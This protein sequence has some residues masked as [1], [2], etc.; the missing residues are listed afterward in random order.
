MTAEIWQCTDS[1][2][3]MRFPAADHE[4]TRRICP[5]CG[6]PTVR[7]RVLAVEPGQK[8]PQNTAVPHIELLLDN[9]RSLHNV[10]S[11]FRT[12]DGAG[13][14]KI[15]L[16]GITATPKHPKLAKTALGAEQRIPWAYHRNGV[17]AVQALREEGLT[18]WGLEEMTTAIS[19][20][21]LPPQ[22]PPQPLLLVIGSEVTGIDPDILAQCQ[23]I[24]SI[25]MVGIKRS[26]NVTIATGIMV[27]HLL[28]GRATT[29][30][31]E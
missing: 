31:D 9:L 15:H 27:Y 5:L 14:A 16:V 12:A 24:V 21:D 11:I 18:I 29:L 17:T 26:L 6:Q 23:R 7:K 30:R 28:H 2:C 3:D 25:P 20:Y 1:S 10:G 22:P 8:E 13:I 4:K 19:L